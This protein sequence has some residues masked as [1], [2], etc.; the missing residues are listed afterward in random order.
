MLLD[1]YSINY[2]AYCSMIYLAIVALCRIRTDLSF[3]F[4]TRFA[5]VVFIGY[6]TQTLILNMINK[7]AFPG[8]FMF[9]KYC[10]LTLNSATICASCK[11]SGAC[12][13]ARAHGM[14]LTSLFM[15][16]ALS[17]QP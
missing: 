3:A 4:I 11:R 15:P 12:V 16:T 14:S 13:T 8:I 10:I 7:L 5:Y 6:F 9:H 2:L 1:K 17:F